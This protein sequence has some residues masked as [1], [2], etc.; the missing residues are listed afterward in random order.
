MITIFYS[1]YI[2]HL[3]F[4]YF[5]LGIYLETLIFTKLD[6]SND[7]GHSTLYTSS[8]ERLVDCSMFVMLDKEVE[9]TQNYLYIIPEGKLFLWPTFEIGRKQVIC[10]PLSP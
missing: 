10:P 2:N 9:S 3:Y 4:S 1:E 5:I 7:Q 8:A 6:L